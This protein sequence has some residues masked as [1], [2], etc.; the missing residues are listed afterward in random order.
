[1]PLIR[2]YQTNRARVIRE[3][4]SGE[5]VVAD[6]RSGDLYS[7]DAVGGK[8]WR[9]LETGSTAA[10][11]VDVVLDHY[12][13]GR[14]DAEIAVERL[15]LELGRAE[16]IITI[17]EQSKSGGRQSSRRKP[18]T[19]ASKLRFSIPTLHKYVDLQEWFLQEECRDVGEGGSKGK[20]SS[21]RVT[22]D[23]FGH[24]SNN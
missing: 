15:L 13:A 5:V 9:L 6:L 23:Q 20:N 24:Y 4:R 8:I 10:E 17:D 22:Y 14:A 21:E 19:K 16:L 11:L 12:D 2:R 18:T 3:T 1:M 7:V